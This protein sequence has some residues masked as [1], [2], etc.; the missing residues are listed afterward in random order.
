MRKA[1]FCFVLAIA[2]PA[3]AADLVITDLTIDPSPSLPGEPIWVTLSIKGWRAYAK[4]I[5]RGCLGRYGGSWG[6]VSSCI[7]HPK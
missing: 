7:S 5:T 6:S 2:L 3:L 4:Y 1:L